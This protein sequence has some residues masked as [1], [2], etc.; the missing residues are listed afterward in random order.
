MKA[1]TADPQLPPEILQKL[2]EIRRQ[3]SRVRLWT[4]LLH[5][6]AIILAAMLIAMTID[7][8]VVLYDS[9]SRWAVTL[10]AL[11]LAAA[12]SVLWGLIPLLRSSSLA[13]IARQ[14]DL[15]HPALEERYSTVPEVA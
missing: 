2:R 4:G 15:A 13:S 3:G 6:I 12:G 8:L 14:V 9:H 10:S 7:W 11:V 5:V 1:P